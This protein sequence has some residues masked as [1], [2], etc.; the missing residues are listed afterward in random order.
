MAE[1]KLVATQDLYYPG[2]G[3]NKAYNVGD[4]VHPDVVEKYGWQDQVVGEDTKAAEA[5]HSAAEDK[6]KSPKPPVPDT[7]AVPATKK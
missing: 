1:K 2:S 4:T 5:A 7:P 3:A 6:A